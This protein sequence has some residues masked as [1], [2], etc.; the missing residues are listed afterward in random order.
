MRRPREYIDKDMVRFAIQDVLKCEVAEKSLGN[1]WSLFFQGFVVYPRDSVIVVV[2]KCLGVVVKVLR[3]INNQRDLIEK[4]RTAYKLLPEFVPRI[5]DYKDEA[6]NSSFNYVLSEFIENIY[7]LSRKEWQTFFPT[8]VPILMLCYKRVG[9]KEKK[10][11]DVIDF[12]NYTLEKYEDK[13]SKF[14]NFAKRIIENICNICQQFKN[15]ELLTTFVHGDLTKDCIHRNIES[16]KIIDWGNA[17]Y[18]S[19]FYDLFIQEF[20]QVN[21]KFWGNLLKADSCNFFSNHFFGAFDSFCRNLKTQT[22]VDFSLFDI[23]ANLLVSLLEKSVAS[24]FRYKVINE[25]EGME[26]FRHIEKIERVLKK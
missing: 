24:L 23:K 13:E 16:F 10:I 2:A 21:S 1:K 19:V 3:K 8:L 14:Y 5:L 11:V 17:G 12:V 25:L 26:F 20:Y 9:F 4:E 6:E 7:P 18:R 22:N 15:A